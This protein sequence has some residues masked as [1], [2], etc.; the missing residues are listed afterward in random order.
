MPAS[1]PLIPLLAIAGTLAWIFFI[2]RQERIARERLGSS[3]PEFRIHRRWMLISVTAL[4]LLLLSI[5]IMEII[6][7][8]IRH[9]PLGGYLQDLLRV[10]WIGGMLY[11]NRRNSIFMVGDA[12]FTRGGKPSTSWSDVQSIDW[13]RDIGQRQWGVTIAVRRGADIE[14]RRFYFRR[15]MKDDVELTMAR[16]RAAGHSGGLDLPAG[17]AR[18]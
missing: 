3:I 11:R 7:G 6:S 1:L 9:L 12:G 16:L 4:A 18:A 15:E 13:D 10:I 17:V 5:P 8:T 2:H 14:R